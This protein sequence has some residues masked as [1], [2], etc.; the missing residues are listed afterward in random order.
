MRFCRGVYRM[1]RRHI[2]K[3]AGASGSAD[4][5]RSSSVL[6]LSLKTDVDEVFIDT[7]FGYEWVDL[8][9]LICGKGI[10]F[11]FSN[12]LCLL[13]MVTSLSF[14][15]LWDARGVRYLCTLTGCRLSNR[16][17][18]RNSSNP[19]NKTRLSFPVSSMEL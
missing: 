1:R 4:L 7:S 19:G 16:L 12:W 14:T 13:E 5:G 3:C 10:E 18:L 15:F 9:A 8:N 6:V 2:V 11:R 17:A